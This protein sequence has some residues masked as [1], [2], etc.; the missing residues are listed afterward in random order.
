MRSAESKDAGFDSDDI[1][2][3]YHVLGLGG[4]RRKSSGETTTF[5]YT[6]IETS[7]TML[8]RVRLGATIHIISGQRTRASVSVSPFAEIFYDSDYG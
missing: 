7:V 1:V 8:C 4:L 6:T 3:G 2:P 5:G